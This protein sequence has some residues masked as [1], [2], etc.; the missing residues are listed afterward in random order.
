MTITIKDEDEAALI[1]VGESLHSLKKDMNDLKELNRILLQKLEER[2][3]FIEESLKQRDEQLM[4]IMKQIQESNHQIAATSEHS[5][6]W[7]RM[8]G[9]K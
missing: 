4:E 1:N 5:S 7:S 2:D 8:F 9:K 6:W 3:Q